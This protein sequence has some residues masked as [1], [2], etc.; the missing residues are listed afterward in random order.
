MEAEIAQL[1]TTGATTVVGL[2]A[3]EAWTQARSRLAALFGR[4]R[5]AE[6]VSAE[7]EEI[8]VEVV[9]A[10]GDAELVG[11]QAAELR[12]RLRRLLREDPRAAAELEAV[13]R[14]F[15]PRQQP[16]D[17]VHNEIHNGTFNESVI[18][19]GRSQV[20]YNYQSPPPGKD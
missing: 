13:L 2:M 18:Q 14:E 17:T 20:T 9:R 7:L 11:D 12:N 5:N 16:G 1:V 10:D 19:A 3:T 4:G 6:E 15:A 8:R